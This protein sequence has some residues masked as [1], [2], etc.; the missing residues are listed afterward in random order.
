LFENIGTFIAEMLQ[1]IPHAKAFLTLHTKTLCTIAA[2][3]TSSKTYVFDIS[4]NFSFVAFCPPSVRCK[5]ELLLVNFKWW[6]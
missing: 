4:T 1:N 3:A 2:S 6:E 5:S